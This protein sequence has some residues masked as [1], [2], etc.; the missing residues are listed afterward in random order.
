MNKKELEELY[1]LK[2][3]EAAL[4]LGVC[5]KTVVRMFRREGMPPKPPGRP[6]KYDI[7]EK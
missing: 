3:K 6:R 2:T 4:K 5:N 7:L 1:K